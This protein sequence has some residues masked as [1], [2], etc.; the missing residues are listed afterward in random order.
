M[1]NELKELYHEK[2]NKE[3]KNQTDMLF[4]LWEKIKG[5]RDIDLVDKKWCKVVFL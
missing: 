4:N 1:K 2:F 3:E 5:N